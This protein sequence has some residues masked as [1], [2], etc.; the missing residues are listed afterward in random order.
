MIARRPRGETLALVLKALR[1]NPRGLTAKGIAAA[2]GID[3]AL[4]VVQL[5]NYRSTGHIESYGA[6]PQCWRIATSDAA[7]PAARP[8]AVAGSVFEVRPGTRTVL[9]SPGSSRVIASSECCVRADDFSP[10]AFMR[11]WE[12]RRAGAVE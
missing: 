7:A 12:S 1:E 9:A 4:C 2:T 6:R 3:L 5:S 8:T 11:D 10:G